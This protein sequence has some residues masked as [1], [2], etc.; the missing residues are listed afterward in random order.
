MQ[1]VV[2][3]RSRFIKKQ[4]ASEKLSNLGLTTPLNKIPLLGDI[5]FRII[6]VNEI[7]NKFHELEI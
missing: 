3:K 5:C 6:N 2:V 4:E 1:Y 7:V